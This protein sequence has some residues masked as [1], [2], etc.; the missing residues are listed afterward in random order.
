[1]KRNEK[2]FDK[3]L[4]NSITDIGDVKVGHLT[5]SK[6]I[7]IPTGEKTAIR[8]GLT[9]VLPYPLEKEKKVFIG[10]SRLRWKN[11]ITGYEV[12]DDF[13]YVN[14]PIVLT[15]TMNVGRVYNAILSFGFAI[16]RDE[17]WPPFVI[18]LNDSYAN[19]MRS[20]FLDEDGILQ[21]LHNASNG[22]VE[23]GSVGIGIGLKS[24]GWKGGIGTSS[25]IISLKQKQFTCGA[26][27]ASNFG[28]RK[29]S[30]NSESGFRSAREDASSLILILGADIPLVPF[31]I[32]QITSSVISDLA[33]KSGLNIH[34]DAVLCVLFSTANA[35]S[36][37][38]E[39]P[40]LHDFEMTDD[41][42]IET[43]NSAALDAAHEA[44]AHSFLKAKP[45]V[46]K[47]G[48]KLETMPE[49]KLRSIFPEYISRTRQ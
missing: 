11:E 35:M 47:Q 13:C 43:I 25:R 28:N 9:A 3:G 46:G 14:S 36:M 40:L 27:V 19:D 29:S 10:S 30:M 2:K 44:I 17:T 20:G 5:V 16:G 8:T 49:D 34:S 4:K 39:R 41:T 6:D 1:M 33:S 24:L 12:T 18:G 22:P 37:E 45:I 38:N 23:E 21:S 26:L 48:V 7:E 15:N 31:Q 42:F 32:K